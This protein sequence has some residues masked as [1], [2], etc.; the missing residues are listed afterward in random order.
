MTQEVILPGQ[1]ETCIST[2][3]IRPE[4]DTPFVCMVV[5]GPENALCLRLNAGTLKTLR[6]QF[7]HL[8]KEMRQ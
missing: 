1:K 5:T 6:N 8:L 3:V 7:D 2:Q 4:G